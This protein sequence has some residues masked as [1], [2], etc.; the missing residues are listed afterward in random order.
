MEGAQNF[1]GDKLLQKDPIEIGKGWKESK[2]SWF[3]LWAIG[4][5]ES[6]YGHEYKVT[7]PTTQTT[8]PNHL[9]LEFTNRN[10]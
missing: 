9:V 4:S 8:K 10:C 7:I 6:N 2:G 3:V 5:L 1:F